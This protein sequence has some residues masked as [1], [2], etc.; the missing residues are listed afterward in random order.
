MRLEKVMSDAEELIKFWSCGTTQLTMTEMLIGCQLRK[1]WSVLQNK[2]IL[3]SLQR[4][5]LYIFGK[6]QIRKCQALT[7]YT[8]SG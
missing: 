4:I 8:D 3:T 2:K 5:F 6:C 7:N 1:S